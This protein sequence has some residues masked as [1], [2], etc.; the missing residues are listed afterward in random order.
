MGRKFMG[1]QNMEGGVIY[2]IWNYEGPDSK[3]PL[4]RKSQV[5]TGFRYCLRWLRTKDMSFSGRGTA[6]VTVS[7]TGFLFCNFYSD[8]FRSIPYVLSS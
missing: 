3:R 7:F 4:S 6:A 8:Q 5:L 2:P 1:L